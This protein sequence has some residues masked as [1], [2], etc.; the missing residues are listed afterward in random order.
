M[1]RWIPPLIGGV[2]IVVGAAGMFAVMTYFA[3]PTASTRTIASGM[4]AA[5]IERMVPHHDDA[6]DMARLAVERAEHPET[7]QL[8]QDIIRTQTAEN[9]RMR[10]WYREWFGTEVPE[11]GASGMMGGM[12][13]G[14]PDLRDLEDADPFDK[15]F[16]EAMVPHHRMGVMMAEMAIRTSA[17]PELRELARSMAAA[18][19][20]EIEDMQRWYQEWYGR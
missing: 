2:L 8:A 9:A 1:R 7:R 16:I 14:S 5:F 3:P 18:Q 11:I 17:R 4:D 12:M 20:A 6:I 19:R 15:A 13:A 10:R